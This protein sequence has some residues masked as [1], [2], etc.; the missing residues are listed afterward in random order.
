MTNEQEL[1]MDILTLAYTGGMPDSYWHTDV[2][3]YRACR[4]LGIKPED[5]QD[6]A[7]K[8]MET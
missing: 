6:V 8:V 1:A 4:V 5:A 2:R 7:R 3:I